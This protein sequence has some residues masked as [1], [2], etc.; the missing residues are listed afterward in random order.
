MPLAPLAPL[1]MIHL[2]S[3]AVAC[4]IFC[5]LLETLAENIGIVGK[6]GEC[7]AI[8]SRLGYARRGA[9]AAII[10][11]LG[12]A[13]QAAAQSCTN[14]GCFQVSCLGGATT[15]ISGI[16]YAP[17]GADPIPNVLVFVPNGTVQPFVDGPA[18]DTES[19][20]VTGDPL[21]QTTSGANGTFTLDNVP[22]GT[23]FPLVLQAGKMAAAADGASG[24]GVRQ[25]A[26][27]EL[28]SGERRFLQIS[29]DS[30][31]G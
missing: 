18:D 21:V 16:T 10:V 23:S 30:A 28:Q 13:T 8:L 29:Q 24:D 22:A 15:S 19:S 3:V 17:N 20:L 4:A 9:S 6:R 11:A 25:H 12:L 31:R 14:Y 7:R 1:A 2:F 5:R 26:G 27:G